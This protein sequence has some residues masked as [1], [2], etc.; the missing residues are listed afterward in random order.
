ML[1]LENH[2]IFKNSKLKIAEFQILKIAEFQI[3]KSKFQISNLK[4][5]RISKLKIPTTGKS[6][7]QG[8]F[9]IEL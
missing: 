3:E 9:K 2:R 1:N 5:H 7:S 4:N 8:A 6:T